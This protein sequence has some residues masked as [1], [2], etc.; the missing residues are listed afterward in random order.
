ML[1]GAHVSIA[2]GVYKAP[3]N[4]KKVSCDVV[5]IFTKSSNQ[6]RAK[7]LTEDDVKGFLRSRRKPGSR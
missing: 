5:Q 2:G 1:L 4:G 6:W 7:P 3:L